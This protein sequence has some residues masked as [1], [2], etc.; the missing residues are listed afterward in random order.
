MLPHMFGKKHSVREGFSQLEARLMNRLQEHKHGQTMDQLQAYLKEPQ[1][2][3]LLV[4]EPLKKAGY[5]TK[6]ASGVW[7]VVPEEPRR[8]G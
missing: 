8:A 6:S 7:D 1:D 3:I 2:K 5:V 4:L